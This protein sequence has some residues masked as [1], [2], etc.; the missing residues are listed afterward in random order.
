M[1]PHGKGR[2]G[3]LIVGEAPGEQEDRDGIQFTGKTG[4]TLQRVLASH[5]IDMRKDCW[6]TNANICRPPNNETPNDK[7]IGYCR[8]TLIKT[9]QELNPTVIILL[10]G[11]A[12]K[13]LIGKYWRRSIGGITRWRGWRIPHRDLNTWI[14]PT[15]HPSYIE[16]M[17][18]RVVS[19]MFSQDLQAAVALNERPY[20]ERPNDEIKII[21]DADKATR[22]LHR[23]KDGDTIAFDFESNPLKPDRDGSY[24]VSCSVC[25]NG[26]WTIA[27]PWYGSVVAAMKRIL[28][29]PKIKK[30]GSNIKH[31][32]RWCK[33]ILDIEVKGWYLDTML[34]AHTLDSRG[35]ITSLK[36]QAFVRLG[37]NDYSAHIEPYLETKGGN[38]WNK[39]KQIDL[40][41]LLQYNGYD[42]LY[43]YQVAMYQLEEIENGAN[44]AN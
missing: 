34:M 19:R 1:E 33:R 42:S 2:K 20:A 6:T 22:W 5:D 14:C 15:F 11:N 27:F 28:K 40:P 4:K 44:S 35:K 3:I 39:I 12:V 8:P 25:K 43:E 31:E 29:N 16:H 24:I 38:E 17:D 13:S 23:I 30:I 7:L 10:G 9:I 21:I 36:F 32:H 37:V 18:N 41:S 26:I